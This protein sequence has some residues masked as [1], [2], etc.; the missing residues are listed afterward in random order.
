MEGAN[1]REVKQ[2]KRL[3]ELR[4]PLTKDEIRE[5]DLAL[6][7]V[8]RTIHSLRE[9][10]AVARHIKYPAMPSIF[11]E[12]IAIAATPILFGEEWK[13]SYGG[14]AS[15]LR[16][17]NS[18]SGKSLRVEVKATGQHAFQEL[19]EKDLLADALV[20]IRF[21]RRYELGT[22]PIEVAVI[23]TLGRYVKKACRLD[24]KRLE[25]IPGLLDGQR[26]LRFANLEEMLVSS[27]E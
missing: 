23:E 13:G 19:K 1:K 2:R 16:I 25:V 27:K 15:D 20:W 9:S 12:S 3:A 26:I 6:I 21:G 24:V 10:N 7:G 22:G 8:F 11:S 5:L 4:E 17:V 18:I 14:Q